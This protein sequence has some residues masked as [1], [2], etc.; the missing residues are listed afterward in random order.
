MSIRLLSRSAQSSVVRRDRPLAAKDRPPSV[1]SAGGGRAVRRTAS[2][3]A[4]AAYTYPFP[5]LQRPARCSRCRC[6]TFLARVA[7]PSRSEGVVRIRDIAA[8]IPA[9]SPGWYTSPALA[10]TTS[11]TVAG[12][13]GATTGRPA[14]STFSNVSEP[15]AMPSTTTSPAATTSDHSRAEGWSN[16]CTL[17]LALNGTARR[18]A[19]RCAPAPSRTSWARQ[20]RCTKVKAAASWCACTSSSTGPIA[21]MV[22]RLAR[23]RSD[24]AA[25]GAG[26]VYRRRG[27]VACVAIFGVSSRRRCGI[28]GMS[29]RIV[30]AI[31]CR[32]G[33]ARGR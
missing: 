6:A 8:V 33:S 5:S 28:T 15:E 18:V 23:P 32:R 12:S 2:S 9:T 4:R 13:A 24:R 29:A 30:S 17:G 22:G 31:I 20:D 10:G 16:V 21:T 11:P 25:I 3:T 19:S 7:I 14:A 1:P 27:P 26:G